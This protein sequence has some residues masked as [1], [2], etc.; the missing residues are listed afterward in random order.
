MRGEDA[1]QVHP[2]DAAERGIEDGDRVTVSNGR[3][4]VEVAAD[5]TPAVR[6]GVAFCTFH[7]AEPL[8]NALTGDAL[9]PEA[10][11]PEFKHSAVA[12]EPAAG[13]AGDG[14]EAAGDD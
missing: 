10:K 12:V 13:E 5:V 4:T 14:S 7:Y 8:A 9:D 11:I 2:S 1:L 3:G 6:E